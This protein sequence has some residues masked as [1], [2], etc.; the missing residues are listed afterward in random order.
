VGLLPTQDEGAHD[1]I[2]TLPEDDPAP[3]AEGW[4][5]GNL[6]NDELAAKEEKFRV[7]RARARA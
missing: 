6:T 3:V 5:S 7:R 4:A 2:G 1:G